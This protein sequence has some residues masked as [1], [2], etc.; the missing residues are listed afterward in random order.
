M[1]LCKCEGKDTGANGGEIELSLA[2]RWILS[3][4]QD[5]K[6]EVTKHVDNYRF[7]LAAKGTLR[8]HV[9]RV[10]RLVSRAVQA[11]ALCRRYV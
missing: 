10:L 4:Q 2:D 9:E 11:S 1:F 8:V 3:L 6:T 7:D 5:L